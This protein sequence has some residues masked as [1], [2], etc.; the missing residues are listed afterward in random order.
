MKLFQLK[1]T[2]YTSFNLGLFSFHHSC[3]T[4]NLSNLQ[5][6][7]MDYIV[8]FSP[9]LLTVVMY[10]SI[11]QHAKGC[12]VVVFLWKPFE[13]CFKPLSKKFNWNRLESVVHIF[14]SFLVLSSTKFISAHA[15][16]IN[17]ADVSMS[18]KLLHVL[19][20]DPNVILFGQHHLPYAVLTILVCTTFVILPCLVLC[21]YPTRV[22]Q[23]CL[24]LCGLRWHAVHAFADVYP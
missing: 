10:I 7:C 4:E 1:P 21:L 19:Y 16:T 20:Y 13:C 12:R 22:F 18:N 14:S 8:A 11:Q 9:L 24:N 15:N 23:E 5:V 17:N 6:L 2:I 3:I